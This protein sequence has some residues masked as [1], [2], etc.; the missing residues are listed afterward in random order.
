MVAKT[1]L[2]EHGKHWKTCLRK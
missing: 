1:T 2:A